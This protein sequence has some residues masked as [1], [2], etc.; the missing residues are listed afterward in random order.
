VRSSSFVYK[1]TQKGTTQRI[2]DSCAAALEVVVRIGGQ[3]SPHTI[4]G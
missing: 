2:K 3:V 1:L 4:L